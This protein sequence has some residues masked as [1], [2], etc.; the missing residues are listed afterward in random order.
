MENQPLPALAPIPIWLTERL[1]DIKPM[2]WVVTGCAG[3]IGSNIVENL[4]LNNQMVV[5]IDNF[6]TGNKG[7]LQAIYE[8]VGAKAKAFEFHE[9]DIQHEATMQS[10][11][12]AADIVLHQAAL[13]S[14]PRSI[15]NPVA[16]FNANVNGFITTIT[17]A[18]NAQVRAFVY[19]SSSAVYGDHPALPK[20][21]SA[22]GSPLSPYAG[23]KVSNELFAQIYSD[24]Y[25]MHCTGLR[26]FNVFGPRQDP[27]GP[28]AAVIPRWIDSVLSKQAVTINGDGSTSRDFCFVANVVQANLL[29]ALNLND[30][31]K[32]R[33]FNIAYG[34]RAS[35]LELHDLIQTKIRARLPGHP[36]SAPLFQNFRA[37]DVLHSHANIESAK[38]QLGYLPEYSLSSG[39]DRTV[40]WFLR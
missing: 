19:A 29:A 11:M 36:I 26:Y 34:S 40:D 38:T 10:V 8:R 37:G 31:N 27:N 4:L 30:Q 16:S 32:K 22:T 18:R 12:S 21:E 13:G 20:I 25:A 39:L 3:F 23:T 1:Q 33:V 7:N 14:V 24:T 35:L 5:G 6:S 17:A 2:R 28:Y 9:G 15:E